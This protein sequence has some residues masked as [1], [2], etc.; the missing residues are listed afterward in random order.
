MSLADIWEMLQRAYLVRWV[1][2]CCAEEIAKQ[3]GQLEWRERKEMSRG[4]GQRGYQVPDSL[5][6]CQP[7]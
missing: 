3:A 6:L 5:E 2:M 4:C 1:H 7:L